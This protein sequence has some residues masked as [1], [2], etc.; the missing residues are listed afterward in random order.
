MLMNPVYGKSEAIGNSVHV[1][2]KIRDGQHRNCESINILN[3][4]FELF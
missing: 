3:G 2:L 4:L 1:I